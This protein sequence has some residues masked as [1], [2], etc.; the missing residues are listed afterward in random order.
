MFFGEFGENVKIIILLQSCLVS[1]SE[2]TRIRF[3]MD[4]LIAKQK[5]VML[6]GSAGSGKTVSVAA[7]LNS[8]PD[9][10]AITNVPLNFYTTSG[11]FHK[12]FYN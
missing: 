10:F 12:Y 8:L 1:T 3:F 11:K 6:V 4:M 9:S 5:P 7:K 2:T